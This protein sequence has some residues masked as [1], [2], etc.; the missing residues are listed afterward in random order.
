[1]YFFK[2]SLIKINKINDIWD[3]FHKKGPDAGRDSSH[4]LMMK[5]HAIFCSYILYFDDEDTC[6][7]LYLVMKKH[8]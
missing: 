1:M 6:H 5:I 3:G 7:I 2:I 8:A 4:I